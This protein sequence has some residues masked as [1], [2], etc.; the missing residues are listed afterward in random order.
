[1]DTTERPPPDWAAI[2]L[3]YE[4][5]AITQGAICDKHGITRGMLTRRARRDLWTLRFATTIPDRA[6]II[7]RLFHLL[8]KQTIQLEEHMTTT[9]EKEVA[10]LGK[11]A[12]TLEKLIAI[13]NAETGSRPGRTEDK[14]MKELRNKLARRIAQLKRA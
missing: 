3:D 11:L 7:R 5:G 12:S 14:D 13:D 1:M 8:E 6:T 9:G 10:V 2:K 4:Y